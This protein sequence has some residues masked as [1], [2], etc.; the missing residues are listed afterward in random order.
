MLTKT[1][2]TKLLDL[3][4]TRQ[5]L[6]NTIQKNDD[7]NEP[8]AGTLAFLAPEYGVNGVSIYIRADLF[9]LGA[10]LYMLVTGRSV[11]PYHNLSTESI[12][13]FISEAVRIEETVPASLKQ[14][15]HRL[16]ELNP[17]DRYQT[18]EELIAEIEPISQQANLEELFSREVHQLVLETQPL[19]EDQLPTILKEESVASTNEIA[20]SP[21][22]TT[23]KKTWISSILAMSSLGI[24]CWLWMANPSP[25]DE[26]RSK[27]SSP[28]TPQS[29]LVNENIEEQ[30]EFSDGEHQLMEQFL[31]LGKNPDQ[32]SFRVE[33]SESKQEKQITDLTRLPDVPFEV[34]EIGEMA[35]RV[36]LNNAQ[37]DLLPKFRRLR[38]LYLD[39]RDLKTDSLRRL[40]D[41]R[42]LQRLHISAE[43]LPEDAEA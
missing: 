26:S 9:S 38:F 6:K 41:I 13:A 7:L 35:E 40:G 28:S 30:A 16:L 32:I 12:R 1:G 37:I 36:R 11:R 8:I 31:Q 2:E 39:G 22:F 10:T 4:L 5:A 42:R 33:F 29:A 17:D 43:T 24:A 25:N 19:F 3:G 15:L 20:N 23:H 27:V 21:R 34:L 14:I 18:P